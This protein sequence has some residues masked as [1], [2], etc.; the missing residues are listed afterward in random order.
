MYNK[1]TSQQTNL[2]TSCSNTR[3]AR[4]TLDHNDEEENDGNSGTVID[5]HATTINQD[6]MERSDDSS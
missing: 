5:Y 6:G 3:A 1:G 4:A 2:C